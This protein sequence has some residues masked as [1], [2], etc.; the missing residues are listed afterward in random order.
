MIDAEAILQ[1][2]RGRRLC[3]VVAGAIDDEG[4]RIP[5]FEGADQPND[6]TKVMRY[7]NALNAINPADVAAIE[8][9]TL[10]NCLSM[11][12]THA[13]YW[14]PP[15]DEDILLAIPPVQEALIPIAQNVFHSA[16]MEHL[17]SEPVLANQVYLEW[18]ID[19]TSRPPQLTG[20]A[21]RLRDW[22]AE[23]VADEDRAQKEWPNGASGKWWSAPC[24]HGIVSTS[25][26]LS[27][28]PDFGATQ[29]WLVEDESGWEKVVFWP[30]EPKQP[31]RLYEISSPQS[32]IDLVNGYPLPVARSYT[33][34]W[35]LATG[36]TGEWFLPDWQAV[37]ADYDAVYLSMPA[38]LAGAGRA[39]Q[40]NGGATVLGGWDPDSTFWLT[41]ILQPA[42][43]SS[44]WFFDRD[45]C[46]QWLPESQ[47]A[48]T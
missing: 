13:R 34:T 16:A 1:G 5:Y 47:N 11:M 24:G 45:G 36:R 33:G 8:D 30:L 44:A 18:K 15:D 19:S 7:V 26:M 35:D 39:L 38:Y 2:P 21:Q 14:Q 32:W 42:G 4:T 48:P 37:S 31:P 17:F 29:L 12:V 27:A 10:L 41:D 3:A 25:R 28:R 43:P 23:I 9:L 22:Q 40:V 46:Q 20:T 6:S